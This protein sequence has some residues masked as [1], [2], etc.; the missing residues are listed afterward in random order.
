M[1][2]PAASGSP[3]QV[4]IV[5]YLP[6]VP[7]RWVVL[8]AGPWVAGMYIGACNGPAMTFTLKR[9]VSDPFLITVISSINILF[10]FM[11]GAVANYLSDRIWTPVGRR[12]PFLL[13]GWIGTGIMV[14]LIPVV[15]NLFVLLPILVLFQ[16][17]IDLSSPYQPLTNEV[18]PQPQRGRAA[19]IST[20]LHMSQAM[21]FGAAII[22]RFDDVY[23]LSIFGR[24]YVV[25]GELAI[26]WMG[27][28]ALLGV[29]LFVGLIV[30][31]RPPLKGVN[32]GK[33]SPVTFFRDI[34]GERQWWMLYLLFLCPG[35]A[36]AWTATLMPLFVTEQLGFTKQE[37]GLSM[38][39]GMPVMIFIAIPIAGFLVD[40]FQHLRLRLFQLGI[41]IPAIIGFCLYLYIKY[42][43]NYQISI[44]LWMGVG[45]FGALFGSWT[46]VSWGPLMFDYMPSSKFGT[47]SAGFGFVN[48]VATFILMN[49]SG[50]WVKFYSGIFARGERTFDYSSIYIPSFIS[51]LIA[52]ALLEFFRVQ[53]SRGK[54]IPFGKLEH[55][56]EKKRAEAEEAARA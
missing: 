2:A 55:E 36:G 31:E 30:K 17:F 39:I 40:K 35:L 5:T 24:T 16:F 29:I 37:L 21:I 33:I 23:R 54:V 43:A 8:M 28:L 53:V 10:N 26:Y 4:R 13:A 41:L 48:G 50:L 42:V 25:T 52:A 46:T 20:M 38:A 45:M 49:V 47:I 56:A 9:F 7:W 12:K 51:A 27:A 3:R 15:T 32:H 14:L 19:T 22:G 1:N 18:T 34:F 11:V 6:H 44:G